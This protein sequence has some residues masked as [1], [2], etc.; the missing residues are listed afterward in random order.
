MAM[1][2]KATL[3]SALL[4]AILSTGSQADGLVVIAHRDSGIKQL[5]RSE[6]V[7]LY[8]GRT[9][10]LLSG[11]TAVP[12]DSSANSEQKKTF[13]EQLV[14]KSLPE[15]QAYWARLLFTGQATPPQQ[16]DSTAEV[17]EMVSHNQ[18]AIAYIDRSQVTTAV[19]I[20]YDF[21]ASSQ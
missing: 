14:N 20:V 2:T 11:I 9:K 6:L 19:I 4:W 3:L 16:A 21:N 12:I 10:K 8:L 5:Q 15:I 1:K 13:Y 18:G 7:N 17:L